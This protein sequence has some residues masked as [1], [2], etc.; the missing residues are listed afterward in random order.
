MAAGGIGVDVAGAT[1]GVEDLVGTFEGQ[2]VVCLAGTDA[3]YSAWGR[4][5]AEALRA[6]VLATLST[7]G[8]PVGTPKAGMRLVGR[9]EAGDQ[10]RARLDQADHGRHVVGADR[11]HSHERSSL[12]RAGSSRARGETIGSSSGA[13]R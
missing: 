8:R 2:A 10:I 3:A 12:R 6:A 5:A 1:T 13:S 11:S 7:G 4:D 9:R